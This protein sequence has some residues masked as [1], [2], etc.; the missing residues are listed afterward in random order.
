MLERAV[1]AMIAAQP[2]KAQS[3]RAYVTWRP[4]IE[5]DP[6]FNSF[7]NVVDGLTRDEGVGGAVHLIH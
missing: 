6:E 3:K 5:R 7:F 2:S 4:T 1:Q